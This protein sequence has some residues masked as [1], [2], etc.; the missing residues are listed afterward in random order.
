MRVCAAAAVS[1]AGWCGESEPC[2]QLQGGR[3]RPLP[4]PASAGSSPGGVGLCCWCG[5]CRRQL[6]L[7]PSCSMRRGVQVCVLPAGSSRR[8]GQQQL[9]GV[10]LAWLAGVSAC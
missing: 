1:A 2:L 7:R 10:Q 6:Q 5:P 8:L 9:Q 4:S 3:W